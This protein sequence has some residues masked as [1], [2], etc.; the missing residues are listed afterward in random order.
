MRKAEAFFAPHFIR[1]S[2]FPGIADTLGVD[3]PPAP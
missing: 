3:Y 2:Y 1:S